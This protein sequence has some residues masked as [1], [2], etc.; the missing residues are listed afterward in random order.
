MDTLFAVHSGVR[1]LVLFSGLIALAWFGW[2]KL[3][4]R[5][6][7][8]PAPALLAGFVGFLDVQVLLGL[9]LLIGGRR[10]PGIWGHVSCMVL[11]AIAIHAVA[12][13]HGRRPRPAGYGLPLFGVALSLA[14]IVL[15]ILAIGRSIL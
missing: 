7:A 14:L 8:R 10:P 15:G 9:T 5:A 13:T 11:A 1:Y 6:F 4:G 2:G 12:K 3:A